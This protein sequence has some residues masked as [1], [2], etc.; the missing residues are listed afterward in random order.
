[1]PTLRAMAA[2]VRAL[3]PVSMYTSW[4]MRAKAWMVC[5]ASGFTVSLSAR[6]K[7]KNPSTATKITVFPSSSSWACRLMKWDARLTSTSLL[8]IHAMLPKRTW[9]SRTRASKPRPGQA[10]KLRGSARPPVRRCA[11]WAMAWPSGCSEPFSALP[12]N[13]SAGSMW[14]QTVSESKVR[15]KDCRWRCT[16]GSSVAADSISVTLGLPS[17]MV[18][19]LSKTTAS[20]K[21]AASRAWPPLMS[22]PLL[23]P[24]PVP[25]ITAVGAARPRAQGHATTST[26]MAI[27]RLKEKALWR[28]A[29]GNWS[30]FTTPKWS[31]SSH[32]TS[33]A[34][35]RTMTVGTNTPE[36]LSANSC[37]GARCDCACSTSPAICAS[38]ESAP[39][40]SSRTCSWPPWFVV[41]P[42]TLSPGPLGTGNASPVSA[43]SSTE[44]SP[45]CTRPSAGTLEPGS[46][47]TRSPF[48]SSLLSTC[49]SLS[50]S[51]SNARCG[52][53]A[54][55]AVMASPVFP[56][57]RHS[58]HFPSSTKV[59]SRAE[60]SKSRCM[61][62]R[63][64]WQSFITRVTQEDR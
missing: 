21:W 6:S 16:S 50:C 3:S 41:P 44:D 26:E 2:A 30:I 54:S 23:A 33:V 38:A 29:S 19:V 43:D 5:A 51:I 48:T 52:C 24:T 11:S 47:R 60:V 56:L 1:M 7:L 40:A 64:P 9:C 63:S 57:A 4:P 12:A 42:T 62:A 35:L 10:L 27:I 22:T 15:P 36:T 8:S 37:T 31:S 17:V 14:L 61:A 18:P 28:S 58:S 49:R 46:T 34:R 45:D 39:T 25:T 32:S 13:Q 20:T 53:K 59:T 55:R